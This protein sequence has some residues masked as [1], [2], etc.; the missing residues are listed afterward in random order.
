[1]KCVAS[2]F[3]ALHT[4]IDLRYKIFNFKSIMLVLRGR[5]VE[6]RINTFYDQERLQFKSEFGFYSAAP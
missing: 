4:E 5:N 3:Y 6:N 1:M 2:K